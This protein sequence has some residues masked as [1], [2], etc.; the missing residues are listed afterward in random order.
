MK[1]LGNSV[2]NRAYNPQNTK[3]AIPLDVDEVDA[4]MEKFIRQKYMQQSLTRGEFSE[5]TRLDIA[6]SRTSED[7][8]PPPPPKTG[9]RFG[10]SLRAASAAL[11]LSRY[12]SPP[13]S[14][15]GPSHFSRVPSPIRG[16]KQSRVFGA[17]VGVSAEG[18]EWK[19]VALRQLG[20]PDDKRNSNILKGLGGDLERT[21][22]SLNRLGEGTSSRLPT[23]PYSKTT[24]T[25]PVMRDSTEDLASPSSRLAP[26]SDRKEEIQRPDLSR[27]EAPPP[28]PVIGLSNVS[29]PPQ[30]HP[31]NPFETMNLYSAPLQP[32]LESIFQDMHVT[33]N[34]FPHST[35]GY[36]SQHQELQHARL[37]QSMTP[38][39]P[40]I[41]Q[42]Y[43]HTNPFASQ[44]AINHNPFL[45]VAS[46][47]TTSTWNNPYP[48]NIQSP[49]S[50]NPYITQT[51]TQLYSSHP[52]QSGQPSSQQPWVA[53]QPPLEVLRQQSSFYGNPESI[54]H[55]FTQPNYQENVYQQPQ[56]IA[57]QRTGRIDNSSIMA[58]YNLP[59]LAPPPLPQNNSTPEQSE[60]PPV[61]QEPSSKSFI[62]SHGQRSV[63]MPAVLT[64]G[65][66]NPFL[67]SNPSSSFN[68]TASPQ[69]YSNQRHVSQDSTE[70][71]SLN[72]GR[73]SPDAFAS[74]SARFVR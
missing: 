57:P 40:Q 42:Q 9:K 2:S 37:Q 52:A 16:N 60:S 3:P 45:N 64:S 70:A 7:R 44:P 8:P 61:P 67:T 15:T 38:P 34:L 47:S 28:N 5:P 74:L 59:H 11:P 22:E 46:Q 58:L 33:P 18:N 35:G 71:G 4:A 1:R 26:T 24:G 41:S 48:S 63:T 69:A 68:A 20:F 55:S 25:G 27:N 72:S 23:P 6:R 17:S 73:H 43:F 62:S 50:Y 12:A 10:F 19:L 14:P 30:Q 31:Y 13:S 39:V 32:P 49:M 51:S 29:P 66:K 21:I 36:P 65:S 56:P 53:V 54:Q